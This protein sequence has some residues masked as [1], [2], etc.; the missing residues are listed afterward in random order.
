MTVGAGPPFVQLAARVQEVHCTNC[1]G[2]ST[3]DELALALSL[4]AVAVAIAAFTYQAVEHREFMR[5][6]RA[7]ARLALFIDPRPAPDA[8]GVIRIPGATSAAV[9]VGLGIENTGDRPARDVLLS[10]LLPRTIRFERTD[11]HGM[12]TPGQSRDANPDSVE[13]LDDGRSE[14]PVHWRSWEVARVVPER[15]YASYVTLLLDLPPS[16][17]ELRVPMRVKLDSEDI[18]G[19]ILQDTIFRF[20]RS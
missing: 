10:V 3:T 4:I 20:A 6:L 8:D 9:R 15:H 7:R 16:R 18:D 5:Q 17:E 2:A 14:V 13:L 12:P 11:E 1:S 19:Q